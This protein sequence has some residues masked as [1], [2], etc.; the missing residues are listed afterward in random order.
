MLKSLMPLVSALG[1]TA[2]ALGDSCMLRL[3]TEHLAC[4]WGVGLAWSFLRA[5][6]RPSTLRSI[7]LSF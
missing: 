5:S 1:L 3:W 2:H 7:L 6:V 4:S